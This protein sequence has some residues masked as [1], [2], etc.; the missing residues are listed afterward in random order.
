[1]SR[2]GTEFCNISIK[3]WLQDN[4]I[5]MH[6]THNQGKSVAPEKFIKSLKN[7]ICKYTTLISKNMYIYKLDDIV[8]KYSHEY[9]S[10]TEWSL[11]M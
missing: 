1:M 6:S 4:D 10:T 5:K 3:S 8:N 2:Q 9:Q 11:S 7:K